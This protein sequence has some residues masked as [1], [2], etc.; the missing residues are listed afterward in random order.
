MAAYYQVYGLIPDKA[1]KLSVSE[2]MRN[3][4]RKCAQSLHIIRF[5]AAAAHERPG[6]A[7]RLPVSRYSQAVERSLHLVGL[8]D[9][10]RS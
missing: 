1:G 2:H 8:Y 6:S 9:G 7:S 4:V 3:I 5:C 10:R